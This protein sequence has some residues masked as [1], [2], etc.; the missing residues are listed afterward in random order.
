MYNSEG[1]EWYK[2]FNW[3]GSINGNLSTLIECIREEIVASQRG[4]RISY[5]AN[6]CFDEETS[7]I[8]IPRDFQLLRYTN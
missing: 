4:L 6:D 5:K 3:Y 7:Q 2:D 8:T 1:V